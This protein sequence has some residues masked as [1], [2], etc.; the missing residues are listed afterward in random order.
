M[1]DEPKNVK[2]AAAVKIS[3][4][5][6]PQVEYFT[7]QFKSIII[8]FENYFGEE[9]ADYDDFMLSLVSKKSYSRLADLICKEN[10]NI[11]NRNQDLTSKFLFGYL[12]LKRKIDSR[13]FNGDK[14]AFIAEMIAILITDELISEVQRYVN[15]MYKTNVDI[16]MDLENHRFDKG[17]TFLD[18][19][20]KAMY[21]ISSLTRLV[22]PLCTHY[23]HVYQNTSAKS[24][25]YDAFV[26][27]F[28]LVQ[29]KVDA[30]VYSKLHTYISRSVQKTKTVDKA[31]WTTI[32]II[33]QTPE[34]SVEEAIK[35]MITDVFPKF[36]FDKNIMNLITVVMR[37]FVLWTLRKEHPYSIYTLS[38][39]EGQGGEDD[40]AASEADIFDSY[41]TKR[42]EM[43]LFLRKSFAED[44]VS[45]IMVRERVMYTPEELKFYRNNLKLHPLQT[46][47][48]F[49][50]F[51]YYFGGS[52]NIHG[53]NRDQYIKLALILT[54]MMQN[55]GIRELP[56]F[57]LGTRENFN[58]RRIS[59]SFD[60]ALYAD[61]LYQEIVEKKYG[62]VKNVF[63]KKDFIRNTVIML[64]NNNYI[65]N[66]YEDPLNGE[67]IEK[68][69]IQIR[70]DVLKF[71]NLL[72]V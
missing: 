72:V 56:K 63:E 53:C 22:I 44:T 57:I 51:A 62:S 39:A 24:F 30:D 5:K 65:H 70:Q 35:K 4:K 59:R 42:D 6:I 29:K 28:R 27:I 2:K 49:Q 36:S 1:A 21:M 13:A 14:D 33:G 25:F 45:K 15:D 58:Y 3:K 71:F 64:I 38:D 34:N 43:I 66:G 67:L 23:V 48:I 52:E 69:E 47:C 61:P 7:S 16:E 10:N 41:N 40:S 12:V 17:T 32:Q 20:F 18:R 19:H 31:M 50:A 26:T 68:D 46:Y 9:T 37:S 11:L 8:P 55:I 60:N 54:K